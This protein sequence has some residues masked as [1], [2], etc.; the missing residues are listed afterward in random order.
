[1]KPIFVFLFLLLSSNFYSQS[2]NLNEVVNLKT[3]DE[4]KFISTLEIKGY[5]FIK[6]SGDTVYTFAYN[7]RKNQMGEAV[8]DSYLIKYTSPKYIRIMF[9]N[10]NSLASIRKELDLNSTKNGT[11]YLD[12]AISYFYN[13]K[14][15]DIMLIYNE[16]ETTFSVYILN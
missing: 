5:K 1:M 4:S 12:N 10:K 3:A 11:K 13:Y 14:N 15:H 6:N 16:V 7:Y 9:F 8:A 2:F